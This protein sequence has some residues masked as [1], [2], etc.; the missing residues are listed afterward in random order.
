VT[1]VDAVVQGILLGGLYALFAC[2]LSL[3]FG[4]MEVINL[5]HGDIAVAAAYLAVVLIPVTHVPALAILVLVV[6]VFVVGGYLLQRGPLQR[7][8]ESGPLTTLLVTFGISIVLQNVLLEVFTGNS[9][10][11]DI[12]SFVS[13][14]IRVTAQLSIADLSLVILGVAVVVLAGLQLFLSRTATGRMI[15]AV[16]DDREASRLV[17]ADHRHIF[18]VAAALAFGTVA[19]GGLALAM[20]SQ[21]DPTAGPNYLI[22]AF[23]AVVIGGLGSLWGTLAGGVVLGSATTVGL[24]VSASFGALGPHL[25]F[26]AVLAFRP[27]G[28]FPRRVYA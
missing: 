23:E 13:D 19:L 21:I 8:L 5:A 27:Q 11:L 14:S 20:Y 17:G 22:Y 24:Q 12:G 18:G 1:W 9:H 6:P 26:L 16:A 2:G 25:V 7:S 28:L 3:L 15:R 4:V 10:S